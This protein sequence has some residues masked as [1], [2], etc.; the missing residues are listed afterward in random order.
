MWNRPSAGGGKEEEK[1]SYFT[2]VSL[3]H[4]QSRASFPF[5]I[6]VVYAVAETM[7]PQVQRTQ[8]CPVLRTCVMSHQKQILFYE[9]TTDPWAKP[10]SS[11]ECH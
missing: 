1:G 4:T 6:S 2:I 8:V 3:T 5:F 10:E 11:K 9:K 7:H